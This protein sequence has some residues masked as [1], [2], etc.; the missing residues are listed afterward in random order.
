MLNLGL[1]E[2]SGTDAPTNTTQNGMTWPPTD[3]RRSS[4]ARETNEG[5]EVTGFFST[6]ISRQSN[7]L[8]QLRA[9]LTGVD[10][11]VERRCCGHGTASSISDGETSLRLMQ[12]SI[13]EAQEVRGGEKDNVAVNLT[14]FARLMKSFPRQMSPPQN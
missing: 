3:Q 12:L 5:Q 6:E 2:A 11:F 7:V 10:V 9:E 13:M 8:T 1:E 4:H 14:Y